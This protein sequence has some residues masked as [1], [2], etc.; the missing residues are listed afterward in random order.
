M[1]NHIDVNWVYKGKRKVILDGET[2]SN[3]EIAIDMLKKKEDIQSVAEKLEI[4]VSTVLG[5]VQEY[6]KEI[7]ENTFDINLDEFFNEDDEKL[8][9]SA[10]EKYGYDKISDLKKELPRFVKYEAIRAVI[11]KHYFVK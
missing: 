3:D 5:Y 1:E 9:I 2:R 6:I 4:S 8:I 7:G 11:L 10:C